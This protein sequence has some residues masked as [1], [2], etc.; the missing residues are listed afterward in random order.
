MQAYFGDVLKEMNDASDEFISDFDFSITE[1]LGSAILSA[2]IGICNVIRENKDEINEFI[3]ELVG[4]LSEIIERLPEIAERLLPSVLEFFEKLLDKLPQL[5]DFIPTALSFLTFLIEHL[6][7]IMTGLG[8]VEGVFKGGEL[9][10]NIAEILIALQ[11]LATTLGTTLPAMASTAGGAILT[12][13]TGPVGIAI[14]VIGVLV[15]LF[16]ALYNNSEKFR[17]AC[18]RVAD[19]LGG[20]LSEALNSIKESFTRVGEALGIVNDETTD[21]QSGFEDLATFLVETLGGAIVVIVNF[22]EA[23]INN[24]ALSIEQLVA[25]KDIVVEFFKAV[26]S[27]DWTAFNNSVAKWWNLEMDQIINNMDWMN[28]VIEDWDAGQKSPGSSHNSNNGTNHGG[29]GVTFGEAEVDE[30]DLNLIS[31]V[32]YNMKDILANMDNVNNNINKYVTPVINNNTPVFYNN[33][34]SPDNID[35]DTIYR[36]ERDMLDEALFSTP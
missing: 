26:G 12:F 5:L 34:Y 24:I 17:D 9:L 13:A 8:V 35:A 11:V 32:E 16:V 33:F 21:A 30:Q 10:A 27:G 18:N 36:Q 20:A 6:P 7:E 14:A 4:S 23:F 29:G 2:V 31:G 3:Q 1:D 28:E 22:L 19:V 15:G 25:M